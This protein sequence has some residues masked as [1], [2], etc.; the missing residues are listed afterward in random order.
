MFV[1]IILGLGLL[2]GLI[3]V[4]GA[5]LKKA[6][7]VISIIVK[8]CIG[9]GVAMLIYQALPFEFSGQWAK[10]AFVIF[11]AVVFVGIIVV[12]M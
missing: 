4:C 11:G 9:G 1:A 6:L 3:S 2:I 5:F 7:E 8:L 10:I 12:C